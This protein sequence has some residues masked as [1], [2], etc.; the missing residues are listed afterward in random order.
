MDIEHPSR[1][2]VVTL[3]AV[4]VLSVFLDLVFGAFR[5]RRT[6]G[7]E[8]RRVVESVPLPTPAEEGDVS[9]EG[10]IADRRSR[11]EYG[12]RALE[13]RE[14]GQLLWAAQGVTER[15][16]GFRAAPSAGALYP[17]ELYVVVG[18]PGV[19]GLESGVYRYRPRAHG[20]ARLGTGDVQSE[21]RQAAVDQAF[22]EAAAVD[23]VLCAVDE[24]TT[25]KYGERGRQRY[26]PMEAGHAGENLYLQ[27]EALGLATV[28]VGAFHDSRVRDLVGAPSNQRPLYVFP[29]GG[30]AR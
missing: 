14:L 12:E 23:I 27:A 15:S 29:V 22:V 13:R 6:G 28:S 5:I 8:G 16:T 20:L 25:G 1:R 2:T 21:L 9:V 17:L 7:E 19:E 10:A 30:R 11:R 24:R 18:T 3:V 4:A 26:V